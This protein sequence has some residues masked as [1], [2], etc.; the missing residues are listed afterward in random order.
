MSAIGSEDRLQYIKCLSY[1]PVNNAKDFRMLKSYA[2][3]LGTG[4][5]LTLAACAPP[6]AEQTPAE[7]TQVEQVKPQ[8]PETRPRNT[9]GQE[10]RQNP[11][12]DGQRRAP[13]EFVYAA[14]DGL[15]ADAACSFETP[16]GTREGVCR[17]RKDETRALCATPRPEGAGRGTGSQRGERPGGQ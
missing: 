12:A 14:C 8:T 4:L 6:A 1:Y 2:L 10:G 7:T 3:I 13:P 5:A 15:A 16:R 9:Q 17:T 11:N